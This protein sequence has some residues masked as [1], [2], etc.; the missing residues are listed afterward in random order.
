MDDDGFPPGF[1]DRADPSPDGDFYG[2]ARLVTHIDEGAIRA[3]GDLYEELA[4]D[5]RGPGPD[6]VLGLAL[7]AARRPGSPCS[8]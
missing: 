2:P 8:G 5:G 6:G 3:V 1:F 4:I 7:P